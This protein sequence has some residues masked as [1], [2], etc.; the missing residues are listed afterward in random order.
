MSKLSTAPPQLDH[1]ISI[2][3]K[4][5]GAGTVMKMSDKPM[6]I[7][8]ISTG[9]I[10][11]DTALGI[12]GLPRGR[13]IE[14]YGKE[15]S[16]K[17]TLAIHV[18]ANAQKKIDEEGSNKKCLYVDVE[19]AFNKEYARR[20]GV[21]VD[22]LFIA[23][24]TCAEEALTILEKLV[25]TGEIEVAVI[26]SI[27]ALVPR[28]ELEGEMGQSSMGVQA[29]LMSQAFRKLTGAMGRTNTMIIFL[30]QT[31]E[32]IGVLFGSPLALPG[33]NATKFYS[34][35]RIELAN[36][37]KIKDKDGVVFGDSIRA[38]VVK[39]KVATPFTQAEYTLRLGYGIDKITEIIRYAVDFGIFNKSGSWYSMGD[40]KIGQGEQ[41]V[42]QFLLDNPELCEEIGNEILK[43]LSE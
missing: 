27:A 31:R 33:G 1:T 35:V 13:A 21:N 25:S 20:L 36:I 41:K 17:S 42:H 4:Q 15:A 34:S 6:D 3:N 9:S 12:G 38:K 39:N 28:S 5:F 7:D 29:R 23:Q 40:N 22:E 10:S 24:P 14:I 43:R 26:D 8:A 37:G 16:G 18:V 11:L 32:K 19:H 2:L 30:N